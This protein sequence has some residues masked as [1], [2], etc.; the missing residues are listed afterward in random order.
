MRPFALAFALALAACSG[1]TDLT[2]GE[3]LPD[4]ARTDAAEDRAPVADVPADPCAGLCSLRPDTV[5]V[6][7]QCVPRSPADAA[8]EAAVDVA[9]AADAVADVAPPPPDGARDTGGDTGFVS[10][11]PQ[12]AYCEPVTMPGVCINLN[13]GLRRDD[14]RVTHCGACGVV[15]AEGEVCAGSCGR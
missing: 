12:R 15:C 14:G 10:C 2:H 9:P 8:A 5:C 7:G 11:G 13:L 3:L 4:A 6:G 1:P